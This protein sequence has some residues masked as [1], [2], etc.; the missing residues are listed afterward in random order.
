MGR[1]AVLKVDIIADAKG[2]KT[3]VDDADKHF[4]RL[5]GAAKGAGI[6]V[7]VGLA[8]GAVA[9]GAFAVSAVGAASSV[10]Q[11][12]GALDSVFGKNAATVKAWADAGST[13]VGLSKSEYAE[14]AAVV[15]AQLT[16]MGKSTDE[17][18][19]STNNLV[20]MG[21][22]LAATFGGTTKDAV[23]ALGSVLKGETDPIER[24]G[25][26][27]K[28]SDINARLAADGHDKLTGTA[29]KTATATAA[30]ALV[31]EGAAK[32]HGAFG[33][34]SDTLA[35]Q[36][37]VLGAQFENVKSTIGAALL[38]ALTGLFGYVGTNLVPKIKEFADTFG[39]KL[40]PALKSAQGF[41]TA[42]VVPA[43]K[44]MGDYATGHLVPALKTVG[45]FIIDNVVPALT[46][47]AGFITDHVIPA[48]TRIAGSVLDGF[49]SALKTISASLEDNRENLEKVGEFLG[50]V[51]D[52]VLKLAPVVGG[53]LK[54][55]FQAVGG[56][57]S[58]VIGIISGVVGVVETAIAAINRLKDAAASV[59]NV[60][61]K[62]N[63]FSGM[64]HLAPMVVPLVGGVSMDPLRSPLAVAS[65][66]FSPVTAFAGLSLSAASGGMQVDRSDRRTV[67]NV[68]GALDPVAVAR[69]LE[70]ILRDQ[71][72]RMGRTTAFGAA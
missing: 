49:R 72:V 17:A 67:I 8:A 48:V 64:D 52:A 70:Q 39:A 26:S 38:P 4:G 35:H 62:L 57:I 50:K 21:A 68:T 7:G 1:P 36:Q 44:S 61:G 42:H 29:L 9:V 11:S 34:E 32:S 47:L 60:V 28:Q 27:I 51:G 69:Q 56:A 12:Y 58:I 65:G 23:S 53:T 22:D 19:A 43:L 6:A 18:A 33:R 45:A 71:S 55:A 15:G 10:Q 37:Q 46:R 24:Y 40:E 66:S 14:L 20:K 13:A 5:G 16:G 3:G 30:L 59:G 63:P 2:V 25:I 31:T 41:V 54:L